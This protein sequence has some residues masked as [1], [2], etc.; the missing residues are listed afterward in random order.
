MRNGFHITI[1]LPN[2]D[3]IDSTLSIIIIGDFSRVNMRN[4]ITSLHITKVHKTTGKNTE[5]NKKKFYYFQFQCCNYYQYHSQTFKCYYIDKFI[6]GCLMNY[7]FPNTS[8]P[9]QRSEISWYDILGNG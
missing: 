1:C 4:I 6:S 9:M 8:I 5:E 7:F 2:T 3:S